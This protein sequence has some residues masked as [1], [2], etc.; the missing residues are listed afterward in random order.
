MIHKTAANGTAFPAK[1]SPPPPAEPFFPG[2]PPP[3]PP[4]RQ[5]RSIRTHPLRRKKPLQIPTAR[6]SPG[7][8]DLP[9]FFYF[10]LPAAEFRR[11]AQAH[12]KTLPG[13]SSREHPYRTCLF[14]TFLFPFPAGRGLFAPL[15]PVPSRSA[16]AILTLRKALFPERPASFHPG[17]PHRRPTPEE[18]RTSGANPR[19]A[20][21]DRCPSSGRSGRPCIPRPRPP[22]AFP[23]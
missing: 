15:R 2:A 16:A 12:Q 1:I 4:L 6:C 3:L 19:G 18:S 8:E 22:R 5:R 17:Q 14:R 21:P 23:P 20:V 13:T 9:G 11:N 7:P 10:R